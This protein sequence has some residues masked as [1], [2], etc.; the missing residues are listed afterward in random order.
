V[1]VDKDPSASGGPAEAWHNS[2]LKVW[3]NIFNKASADSGSDPVFASH[4]LMTARGAR[5]GTSLL[6][7]RARF[8]STD[9]ISPERYQLKAISPAVDSGITTADGMTPNTDLDGLSRSGPPDR[10]A[11]EYRPPGS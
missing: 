8:V 3:N 6:T 10:G 9:P 4:N 7:G 11:R 2:G 1:T 5:F